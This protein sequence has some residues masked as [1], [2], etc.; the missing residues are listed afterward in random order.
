MKEI[1]L[2]K[3]KV[4]NT[5][6]ECGSAAKA[7][8]VLG[9][10]PSAI[11][12][13]LKQLT[14]QLDVSPFIRKNNG[15]KPNEHALALQEKYREIMALNTTR[16]KFIIS[17]YSLIEFYLADYINSMIDGTLLHFI[18]MDTCENERLRKLQH[19]EVDID[20]GGRLPK[21]VSI[22]SKRYLYS[23]M[24]IMASNNH[25]TI[26]ETF[27]LDDWQTNKHLRWQRD[28]GSISSMVNN[29]DFQTPLFRERE[30]SWE[31]PNLLTLAYL[32]SSSDNII[33]IPEVF[34]ESLKGMFPLKS[35]RSPEALDMKFE[36][37]IHYHRALE[38]KVNSLDLHNIFD[39][40]PR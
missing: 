15:L 7:A 26:N 3:L 16:K 39:P 10:S 13:T 12:Y 28:S 35:F 6:I 1:S 38:N 14:A 22:V 19:R 37:Y 34:V 24:C 21:D 32:C 18:T 5:L 29:M 30:I 11:S 36:C 20:I 8:K 31:S 40:K 23:K 27:T 2:K 25:P 33:M 4:V 9:I 17:T